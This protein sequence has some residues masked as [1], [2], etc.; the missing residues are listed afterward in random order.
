MAPPQRDTVLGDCCDAKKLLKRHRR[1]NHES[2]IFEEQIPFMQQLLLEL[3]MPKFFWL[4][5][6]D[7]LQVAEKNWLPAFAFRK[8]PDL[9][10]AIHGLKAIK[11]SRH[12]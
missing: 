5:L 4:W 1:V 9:E 2:R 7:H 12:V 11:T 10:P 3:L 6:T 8:H